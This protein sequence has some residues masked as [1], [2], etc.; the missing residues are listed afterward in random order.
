MTRA[1]SAGFGVVTYGRFLN[2]GEKSTTRLQRSQLTFRTVRVPSLACVRNGTW[3]PRVGCT[4]L[5][6]TVTYTQPHTGV[7]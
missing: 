5:G 1:F 4:C 6:H 7:T 2:G 3:T